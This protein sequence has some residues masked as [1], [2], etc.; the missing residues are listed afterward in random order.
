M[1]LTSSS[2]YRF[3]PALPLS[4][5]TNI[6]LRGDNSDL[7][8]LK[9]AGNI[10]TITLN[11]DRYDSS[12]YRGTFDIEITNEKLLFRKR[13]VPVAFG[14]Y[15]KGN[16][17]ESDDELPQGSLTDEYFLEY[18]SDGI[19][20]V[21]WRNTDG[22]DNDITYYLETLAISK[23]Q[24]ISVN[25]IALVDYIAYKGSG[26]MWDEEGGY[27]YKPMVLLFGT[28][29]HIP[30]A[31]K[32]EERI[33][34]TASNNDYWEGSFEYDINGDGFIP[35]YEPISYPISERP[36]KAYIDGED[37]TGNKKDNKL[38][39]GKFDDHI[40]GKAGND[41]I[42]GRKGDDLLFGSKGSDRIYGAKGNDY[43]SG[44]SGDDVLKGGKGADVF[45]LSSGEDKIIDFKLKQQDKVAVKEEHIDAIKLEM[46][47][48]GLA[49]KID[50]YGSL[51]LDADL[52][53]VDL[54]QIIVRTN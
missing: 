45:V 41:F 34:I 11:E 54:T 51:Q 22:N 53:E 33:D 8:L 3:N 18:L 50:G 10:I 30:N 15:R 13:G 42:K 35:D 48:S 39:G 36:E 38:K 32:E 40:D 20:S 4:S 46:T 9:S 31:V 6:E 47:S 16:E 26:Y 49:L 2:R 23:R 14:F 21:D 7:Q 27:E 44:G 19:A 29:E 43:I 37:L 1:T 52:L 25:P 28:D 17:N 5:D 12:N 24:E